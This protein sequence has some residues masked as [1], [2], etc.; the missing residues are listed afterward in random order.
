VI[1]LDTIRAIKKSGLVRGAV[2]R[3]SKST[4]I[5]HL[6]SRLPAGGRRD[7]L[8]VAKGRLEPG[9]ILE[10]TSGAEEKIRICDLAGEYLQ[11]VY[12]KKDLAKEPYVSRFMKTL[13]ARSDLGGAGGA[14][15]PGIPAPARPDEGHHSNR[16]SLGFGFDEERPFQELRIRPAYHALLDN[17]PGYKRGSQ[18]VFSDI[19]L[20]YRPRDE[21]LRLEALDL[22]DIVSIAPRDDFFKHTSWKV[23]TDLFRRAVREDGDALVYRLNPGFG[24]AYGNRLL[25]LWYVLIETDLH[26][27]GALDGGYS[28]G[29][30][31]SCG[32]LRNLTGSWKIHL[33]AGD[34]D[35]M[36]GDEDNAITAGFGQNVAIGPDM[37]VSLELLGERND[38]DS[39]LESVIRWN[40]FF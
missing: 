13:K 35:Y 24:R 19:V 33:F 29:A 31:A 16:A 37:S 40:A 22:I 23:R 26:V 9:E 34:I 3:P 20:R 7:A 39:G 25:G 10:R 21:R 38:H 2:Y 6:A 36:L 8:A 32:L 30:G 12:A 28:A 18:I 14:E 27:G 1:P 15:D 4:K 17:D 11:Y 5:K